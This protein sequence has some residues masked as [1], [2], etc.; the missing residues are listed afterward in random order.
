MPNLLEVNMNK[1]ATLIDRTLIITTL[2][3]LLPLVFSALVYKDLPEQVAIHFDVHGVA[4]NYAS[5]AF[6]AFGLPILLAL[7]NVLLQIA[8]T[9]DPKRDPSAKIYTL[10]RWILA[11]FSLFTSSLTL[12]I[13]LGHPIKVERIVPLF[14][15]I[16]LLLIA[17]YLPKCKQNYTIGIKLP[18]TLASQTNWRKTHRLAGWLYCIIS[19]IFI[20][21][22]ILNWNVAFIFFIG[23]ALMLVV[24]V[25]YSFFYHLRHPAIDTE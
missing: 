12:L 21:S 14:V 22:I 1:K 20:L 25:V 11:P 18:W 24:P 13:A 4:D 16:I 5:K 6:A 10:S 19:I 15:S 8:L 9:S 17:N 2:L 23:L 3:C 7:M